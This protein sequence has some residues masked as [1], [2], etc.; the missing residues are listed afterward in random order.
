MLLAAAVLLVLGLVALPAAA[1]PKGGPVY[2]LDCT[3]PYTGGGELW[4]QPARSGVPGWDYYSD[5]PKP[6]AVFLAAIFDPAPPTVPDPEVVEGITPSGLTM[7]RVYG[8]VYPGTWTWDDS[9][10][11]S[12][13]DFWGFFLFL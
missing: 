4:A 1:K 12:H 3:Y 13:L 6:L 11:V 7:C 8:P 2:V 5:S 9:W 10:P